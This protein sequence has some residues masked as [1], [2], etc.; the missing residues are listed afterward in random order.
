[1]IRND[2]HSKHE[3]EIATAYEQPDVRE[4]IVK[5]SDPLVHEQ[6]GKKTHTTYRVST[7]VSPS[8]ALSLSSLSL[9]LP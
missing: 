7:M 1:M 2:L 4:T 9:S 6:N 5:V 8:F 3:G